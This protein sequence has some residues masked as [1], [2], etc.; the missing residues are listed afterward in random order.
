MS[1]PKLAIMLQ[2]N[3]QT[4]SAA[5]AVALATDW[6]PAENWD[7]VENEITRAW[8]R[9]DRLYNILPFSQMKIPVTLALYVGIMVKEGTTFSRLSYRNGRRKTIRTHN[10]KHDGRYDFMKLQVAI[11]DE[12]CEI[13]GIENEEISPVMTQALLAQFTLKKNV[14]DESPLFAGIEGRYLQEELSSAAA[15]CSLW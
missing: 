3:Q 5:R 15:P 2:D 14:I 6:H 9:L 10:P 4:T 7:D 1:Y 13:R 12:I 11:R 8:E